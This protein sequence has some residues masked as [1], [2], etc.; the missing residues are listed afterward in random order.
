LAANGDKEETEEQ[1]PVAVFLLTK[2]N[3]SDPISQFERQ[4]AEDLKLH[5]EHLQ[6][7]DI[8]LSKEEL[9]EFE[10]NPPDLFIRLL[11]EQR[12]DVLVYLEVSTKGQMTLKIV[13]ID[14]THAHSSSIRAGSEVSDAG[15]LAL[16][17][18]EAL[19]DSVLFNTFRIERP[20][21]M[22][23]P[24]PCEPEIITETVEVEKIVTVEAPPKPFRFESTFSGGVRFGLAGH[25]GKNTLSTFQFDFGY[26]ILRQWRLG[27]GL[28]FALGPKSD[29]SDGAYLGY[30]VEPSIFTMVLFQPAEIFQ[31]DLGFRVSAQYAEQYMVYGTG[32]NEAISFWNARFD[33]FSGF[34]FKVSRP[35][36]L[37]ILPRLGVYTHRQWFHRES[38]NEVVL[39]TPLLEGAVSAGLRIYL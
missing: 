23:E 28:G 24:E 18:K 8:P 6:I 2:H 7:V 15:G 13:T 22:E 12:A 21:L 33:L 19:E 38:T 37:G 25:E 17:A 16:A 9:E 5:S 35:V 34:W 14:E 31:I 36:A 11:K 32:D 39:R 29:S 27:L 1:L 30:R 26:R 10:S 3:T 4:L 20:R